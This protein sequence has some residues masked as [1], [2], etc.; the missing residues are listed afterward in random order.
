MFFPYL[1]PKNDYLEHSWG[2]FTLSSSR[3]KILFSLGGFGQTENVWRLFLSDHIENVTK[4]ARP[5][6][7]ISILLY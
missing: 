5:M 3:S 2:A 4:M 6:T 7:N 1:T